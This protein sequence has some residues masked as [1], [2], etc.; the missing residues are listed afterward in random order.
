MI[1]MRAGRGEPAAVIVAYGD[2]VVRRLLADHVRD[3]GYDVLEAAG[4]DEA[5]AVIADPSRPVE[6]LL[7]D[8]A[9][10]GER[11]GFGLTVEAKDLRPELR[12]M[13]TGSLGAAASAA[14]ELCV[15][16]GQGNAAVGLELAETIRRELEARDARVV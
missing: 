13:L 3:C 12:V 15:R 2:E 7:C 6:A 4:S 1:G 8:V 14:V 11:S 9:I 5:M 16:T 10:A